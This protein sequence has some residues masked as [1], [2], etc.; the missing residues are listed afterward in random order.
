MWSMTGPATWLSAMASR[1][2]ACSR[3]SSTNRPYMSRRPARHGTF[4][5]RSSNTA[6]A[7][8]SHPGTR[9]IHAPSVSST[10]RSPANTG[11]A[12]TGSASNSVGVQAMA[13]AGAVIERMFAN[14]AAGPID[15]NGGRPWRHSESGAGAEQ[16]A[17]PGPDHQQVDHQGDTAEDPQRHAHVRHEEEHPRDDEHGEEGDAQ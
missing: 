14:V 10:R 12:R 8:C 17:H 11:S 15:G 6:A 9:S 1:R 7:P 2:H 3:G 4:A 16:V 13:W 5:T